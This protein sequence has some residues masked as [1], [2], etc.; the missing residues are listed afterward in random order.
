MSAWKAWKDQCHFGDVRIVL[1]QM[2]DDLDRR[3]EPLQAER[4]RQLGLIFEAA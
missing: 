1:R 3:T 4:L 2:I